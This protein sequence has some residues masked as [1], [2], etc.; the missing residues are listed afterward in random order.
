MHR[1]L[2]PLATALV[3]VLPSV[4][5]AQEPLPLPR[6]WS[7]FFNVGASAIP[8]PTALGGAGGSGSWGV[9]YER[10]RN[11]RTTWRAELAY[12]ELY[13]DAGP[14]PT[15]FTTE[16]QLHLPRFQVGGSIRRYTARNAWL[17]G[18]TT[19]GIQV[20]CYVDSRG[21]IGVTGIYSTQCTDYVDRAIETVP[22]AVNLLLGA[23]FD[24][25]RFG[26][27]VR[28]EQALT[29]TVRVEGD[30]QRAYAIGAEMQY[31]FG[32]EAR[33]TTPA[34][35]GA[36]ATAP[37]AGQV[38]AGTAGWG[39]GA[40]AGMLVGAVVAKDDNDWVSPIL[41]AFAGAPIGTTVAIHAFG[42]SKGLRSNVV[43]TFGGA[44]AGMFG[45]PAMWI[46]SPIG[47]SVAYNSV[48]RERVPR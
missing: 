40:L 42:R 43:V 10:P 45:G 9:A 8:G 22:V 11:E 4:A 28:A 2:R 25:G 44:L 29:P 36:R 7:A 12:G 21:G 19:L 38:A 47:A 14:A 39:V 32:H 17:S 16:N 46:T 20:D 35:R 26:F 15:L 3:L 5:A 18:G 37:M 13:A 33:G 48:S 6:G 30:G 31:R 23:G 24:R 1:L 41:G 34:P 27:A